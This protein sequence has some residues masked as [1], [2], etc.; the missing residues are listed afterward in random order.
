MVCPSSEVKTFTTGYQREPGIAAG[1]SGAFVIV[2]ESQNQ[3]GDNGGIYGQRFDSAGVPAGGEFSVNTVTAQRQSAASV[4]FALDHFLVS[5]DGGDGVDVGVSG[6]A[7]DAG[8]SPLAPQFE[9]VSPPGGARRKCD[10]G[11][12]GRHHIGRVDG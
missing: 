1:T 6:R 9:V 2:W 12:S 11:R 3:D 10:G 7:F 8:G 4:A 5:W